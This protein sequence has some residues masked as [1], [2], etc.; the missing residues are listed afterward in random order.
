MSKIVE[1]IEARI[2]ED[3]QIA[4]EASEGALAK[5]A[6]IRVSGV[7][8][9]NGG[10]VVG[11][12]PT[13]AVRSGAEVTVQQVAHIALHDPARAARQASLFRKLLV[14]ALPVDGPNFRAADHDAE[15]AKN[16][17]FQAL[18]TIWADHPEFQREWRLA[19]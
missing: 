15:D 2:T 12:D 16:P 7:W 4:R 5:F 3:E 19:D 6:D 14:E 10:S 8:E 18:A 11:S 13:F 1:F 17:Q 9:Y